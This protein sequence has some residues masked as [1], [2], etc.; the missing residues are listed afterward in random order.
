M[1]TSAAKKIK[2]Q[3]FPHSFTKY[4]LPHINLL[5]AAHTCSNLLKAAHALYASARA[6]I[7]S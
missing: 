6:F 1:R 2:L 3:G 5:K 7:G 4:T